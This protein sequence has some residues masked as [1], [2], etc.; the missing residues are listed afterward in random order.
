MKSL[1]LKE[2]FVTNVSDYIEEYGRPVIFKKGEPVFNENKFYFIFF[3]TLYDNEEHYDNI[4][5]SLENGALI[6]IPMNK[7][8][9]LIN[10]NPEFNMFM[11][12]YIVGKV[13]NLENIIEDISL[14]SVQERILR[15]ISRDTLDNNGKLSL[16]HDL[17]HEEIAYL[18]GTIRKVFNRELQKLKKNG[19]LEVKR[20]NILPLLD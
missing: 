20:K 4:D 16:I 8:R 6:E 1:S 2:S 18:V 15:L 19:V 3:V 9:D 17:P 12:K 10:K 14:Y 11:A 7:M 5:T 13:R